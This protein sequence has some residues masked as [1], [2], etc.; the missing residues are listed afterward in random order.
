SFCALGILCSLGYSQEM[1]VLDETEIQQLDAV[2]G[3][4]SRFE[5]K[6]ENSGKTIITITSEE[7]Q[8]NQ[9]RSLSELINTKS[10]IEINGSRS[11][12]GQN[13][14]YLIRG[15]NNRQVLFLIDGIVVS[16]PSQ[17][18]GDF[19]LKLVDLANVES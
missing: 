15:G 5:L 2:V 9:G 6:R 4:D 14:S 10:G 13:L 16:D 7:L 1:S 17:I 19:D 11:T 12:A 3:S 18:A 8:R